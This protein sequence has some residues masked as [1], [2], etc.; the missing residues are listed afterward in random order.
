MI[1]W[2]L[3]A[4]TL[5]EQVSGAPLGDLPGRRS[6]V[7]N[8]LLLSVVVFLNNSLLFFILFLR[9]AD[10]EAGTLFCVHVRKTRNSHNG[11]LHLGV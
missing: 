4:D 2:Y 9:D 10:P 5:F 7:I 1:T 6:S 8:H 11:P 3:S